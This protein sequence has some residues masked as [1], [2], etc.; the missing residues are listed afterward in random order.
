[1]L[2]PTAVVTVAL[3]MAH[4]V[5][6]LAALAPLHMATLA[7]F[8]VIVGCKDGPGS[9][10]RGGRYHDAGDKGKHAFVVARHDSVSWLVG[11]TMAGA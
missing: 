3:G 9:A 2:L 4:A 6:H 5:A 11:L 7:V 10:K 1:M 8:A